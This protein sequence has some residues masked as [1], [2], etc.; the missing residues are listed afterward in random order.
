M[1]IG[2][3]QKSFVNLSMMRD[4]HA[5]KFGNHYKEIAD[6][7]LF[8]KRILLHDVLHILTLCILHIYI[9]T[10]IQLLKEDEALTRSEDFL[11]Q[12]FDDMLIV[13]QS[14][15]THR[16]HLMN[17]H[18]LQ[19]ATNGIDKRV[20]ILFGTVAQHGLNQKASVLCFAYSHHRTQQ[21]LAV[22]KHTSNHFR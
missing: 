14:L 12:I 15:Q 17:A 2:I 11:V 16:S 10:M 3:I 4:S 18:R 22:R 7:L 19:L 1:C 20:D 6:D 9:L 8:Q 13:T 21:F 5:H